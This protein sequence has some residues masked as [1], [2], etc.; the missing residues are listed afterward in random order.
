[1]NT[2]AILAMALVIYLFGGYV[3]KA[4]THPTGRGKTTLS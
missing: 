1:M 2:L 3:D 4:E